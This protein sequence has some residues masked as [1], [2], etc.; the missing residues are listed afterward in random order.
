MPIL[1]KHYNLQ[2]KMRYWDHLDMNL[3]CVLSEDGCTLHTFGFWNEVLVYKFQN[4]EDLNSLAEDR[5]PALEPT[6]HYKIQPENQGLLE[7]VSDIDVMSDNIG[8]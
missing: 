5:D 8:Q 2:M 1:K 3:N 6:C 4:E 7:D